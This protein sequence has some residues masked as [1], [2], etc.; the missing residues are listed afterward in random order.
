MIRFFL[1]VL[2][3]IA[4]AFGYVRYDIDLPGWLGLPDRLKGNIISTAAEVDLYDLERDAATRRRA[5]ETYFAHRATDAASVDAE[6]GH[7]FL[8]ALYR[9]RAVHEARTLTAEWSAYESILAKPALRAELES[10]YGT[11]NDDTLKRR[12]LA[13]S[14]DKKLFLKQWLAANGNSEDADQLSVLRRLAD[15]SAPL[16]N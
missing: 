12:M 9:R 1:G 5:L 3:G 10:R 15:Q 8:N 14:L 4:V 16:A 2:F 13:A 11:S 6:A 7:P